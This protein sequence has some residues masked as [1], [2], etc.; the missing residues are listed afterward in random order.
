MIPEPVAESVGGRRQRSRDGRSARYVA[1]VA[2]DDGGAQIDPATLPENIALMKEVDAQI[3]RAE[4]RRTR[5]QALAARISGVVPDAASNVEERVLARGGLHALEEDLRGGIADALR[6]RGELVVTEAKLAVPGWTSNLG[7]FD[8]AIV[9]DDS[10]VVAETKLADGNL[11]ESMWDIFKLAS[12]LSISRVDAAVAIYG[13]PSKQWQTPQTCAQ[14]FE[15][16]DVVSPKLIAALP[17]K[18]ADNL[19]GSSAKPFA[20]PV[21]VKLRLLSATPAEVLGKAWEVR[22][23]SVTAESADYP[24]ED[25]WPHGERPASPTPY[26]W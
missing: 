7:G 9:A 4:E 1:W 5:Q 2:L 13:A 8:L 20:I 26:S 16:R 6:A 12:A 22:A 21:L 24:L 3:A 25:G 23:I 18:W 11:H 10:L 15:D 17:D 14:L 19:A